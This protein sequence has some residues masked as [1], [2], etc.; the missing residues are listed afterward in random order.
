MNKMRRSSVN[1]TWLAEVLEQRRESLWEMQNPFEKEALMER[2]YMEA[3]IL[4]TL[5][6]SNGASEKEF[7]CR[8]SGSLEWRQD[9]GELGQK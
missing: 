6:N 4:D 9:R 1:E 2:H 5:N 3:H 7:I 8:Q